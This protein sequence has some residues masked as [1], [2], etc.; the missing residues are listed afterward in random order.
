MVVFAST[1][2]GGAGPAGTGEGVGSG[3]SLTGVNVYLAI[4]TTPEVPSLAGPFA[5]DSLKHSKVSKLHSQ[6]FEFPINLYS[7]VTTL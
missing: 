3:I 2:V 1:G 4:A 6:S 5:L 7:A